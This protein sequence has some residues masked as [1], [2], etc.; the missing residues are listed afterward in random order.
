M[1]P[2]TQL[3]V[4]VSSSRGFDML[5]HPV[6]V[7]CSDQVQVHANNLGNVGM[8]HMLQ[9]PQVI[10]GP[11]GY[12]LMA[13]T[14]LAQWTPSMRND[15]G[16][17]DDPQAHGMK[18]FGGAVGPMCTSSTTSLCQSLPSH[19]DSTTSSSLASTTPPLPQAVVAQPKQFVRPVVQQ[20]SSPFKRPNGPNAPMLVRPFGL[21]TG[22][23]AMHMGQASLA[24]SPTTPTSGAVVNVVNPRIAE[25][26]S[27][28]L[29]PALSSEELSQEMANLEGLMKDLSVM[30]ANQFEIN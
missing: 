24:G 16:C 10:T 2:R 14:G 3:N 11:P 4:P 15:D 12:N 27:S 7:L 23:G 8:S 18:T 5:S 21:S 17:R 19:R 28:C 22:A 30:T 20:M 25:T 13:T 1:Y 29:K 9:Q 6:D 26:K